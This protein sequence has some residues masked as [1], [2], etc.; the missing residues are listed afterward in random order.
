MINPLL[1][2]SVIKIP[3]KHRP[4]ILIFR[5]HQDYSCSLQAWVLCH[6]FMLSQPFP[7]VNVKAAFNTSSLDTFAGGGIESS[8]YA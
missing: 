3:H 5:Y 4:L 8:L 1:S 7:C 6:A 2:L